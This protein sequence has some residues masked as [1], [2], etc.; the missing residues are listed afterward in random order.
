MWDNKSHVEIIAAQWFSGVRGT[1]GHKIKNF[2]RS[3]RVYI[4]GVHTRFYIACISCPTVPQCQKNL[5]NRL[6]RNGFRVWDML[7]HSVHQCPTSEWKLIVILFFSV[8]IN[9]RK[10]QAE[11]LRWYSVDPFSL[12]IV[13]PSCL[14]QVFLLQV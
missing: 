1:V 8:Q 5:L 13:S 3:L 12:G 6:R 9:G 4:I 14:N 11:T 10:D 7:S 2:P